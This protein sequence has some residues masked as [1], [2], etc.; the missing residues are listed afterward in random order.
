MHLEKG[1]GRNFQKFANVEKAG[2]KRKRLFVFNIVDVVFVLSDQTTHIPSGYTFFAAS[3]SIILKLSFVCNALFNF[4]YKQNRLFTPPPGARTRPASAR[5]GR[6]ANKHYKRMKKKDEDPAATP[7]PG[8]APHTSCL[9]PPLPLPPPGLSRAVA[10]LREK[11]GTALI[12]QR[13]LPIAF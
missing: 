3:L 6:G 10:P 8:R 7:P 12:F 11:V 2:C 5:A 4:A 9:P 1:Y 13:R